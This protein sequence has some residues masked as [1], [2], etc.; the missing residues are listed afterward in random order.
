MKVGRR[1]VNAQALNTTDTWPSTAT[2]ANVPPLEGYIAPQVFYSFDLLAQ[3]GKLPDG[4]SSSASDPSTIDPVPESQVDPSMAPSLRW[5]A[6]G[7][8]NENYSRHMHSH[9]SSLARGSPDHMSITSWS[10][11]SD[12]LRSPVAQEM[13][14]MPP[15][16]IFGSS[17]AVYGDLGDDGMVEL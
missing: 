14:S 10:S 11:H 7:L 17:R 4:L 16:A 5:P 2:E 15:M 6:S 8:Q 3:P 12:S 13:D 9:S 1:R